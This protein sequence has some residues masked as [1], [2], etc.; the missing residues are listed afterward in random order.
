MMDNEVFKYFDLLEHSYTI[1]RREDTR[2]RKLEYLS[3]CIFQFITYDREMSEFLAIKAIEV[4]KA[5]TN[6]E[7]FK[8]IS[9]TDNYIW[10]IVMCNLPFC[11]EKIEWGTSIRGARW[12]NLQPDGWFT[13]QDLALYENEEQLLTV[14]FNNEQWNSFMQALIEF[15]TE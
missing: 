12:R 8:L 7:N 2:L 14:K 1:E 15:A 5:I 9:K 3:E 6:K 13:L 4:C 10:Y 11:A